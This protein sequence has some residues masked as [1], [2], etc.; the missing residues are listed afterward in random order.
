MHQAYKLTKSKKRALRK[1]GVTV[2][3]STLK[4]ITPLTRNQNRAFNAYNSGKNLFLFG[5]AGTGKTFVALYLLLKDVLNGKYDRLIIMRSVVPSRDMGFLPG[6]KDEKLGSYELPYYE[7]CYNLFGRPD[8]YEILKNENL[9]EFP[10]TSHIRGMTYDNSAIL[11]DE[12]QNMNWSELSTVM[13]RV[14]NYSRIAFCGDTK[15]SDLKPH[16]GKNDLLKMMT[17]C[18]NM[19]EFEFIQMD[20]DDIVRSDFQKQFIIE[21][22]KLG[23]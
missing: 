14:G 19:K 13:T 16:E 15:Q 8:A 5:T 21:C 17:V 10:S 7:L 23:Y 20:I 18:K 2:D 11:V 3:N 22:E 4:Q 12:C 9:I 6:S 1:Q